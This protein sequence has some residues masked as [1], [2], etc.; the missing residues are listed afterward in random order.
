MTHF[1]EVSPC[2]VLRLKVFEGTLEKNVAKFGSMS[3]FIEAQWNSE[4][5]TSKV[6]PN[7]HF[8]PVWEEC[9]VF[10][11][12]DPAPL[13]IKVLHHSII[14]A[15]QEIGFCSLSVED[16]FKGKIN[17]CVDLYN[18]GKNIG[19]IRVSVNM[20]E[21]RRS[22]QS[23]HNTSY[24]S[25]DL[26]EEYARKLNE[27]EL[28]KEE[29]EFY[30]RKYKK[31]VEKLNQEKRN[32]KS[33]VTEFVRKT[34]PNHTEE[35]SDED[36]EVSAS[37][38]VLF[39]QPDE[40]IQD[41]KSYA[42]DKQ[43]LQQEKE[44]LTHLKNQLTFDISRLRQDK[45]R[46]LVRKRLYVHTSEKLNE[47]HRNLD[48]N[49]TQDGF[50]VTNKKNISLYSPQ[51]MV[52]WEEVENIKRKCLQVKDC[53]DNQELLELKFDAPNMFISPKRAATPKST[54]FARCYL[55]SG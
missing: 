54:D 48:V 44:A 46:S 31:K 36:V 38:Y 34:T 13:K 3:P 6:S 29:L 41:E 20:Y 14:F 7:G 5:W 25:V 12:L 9:H 52:D 27:L 47:M 33:K 21:E 37:P 45:C 11:A 4:K 18:E 17:E 15:S 49:K 39:S 30:K 1:T 22:E 32:Y 35:S 40:I 19:K 50:R 8:N 53:E 2:I 10:E 28:E 26:K 42:N 16:L 23:T 43:L 24:A 51:N 55:R